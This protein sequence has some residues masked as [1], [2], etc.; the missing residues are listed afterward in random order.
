MV[1]ISLSSSQSKPPHVTQILAACALLL[2]GCVTAR[3]VGLGPA[4]CRRRPFRRPTRWLLP[5]LQGLQPRRRRRL[6]L[7]SRSRVEEGRW[8]G[9]SRLFGSALPQRPPSRSSSRRRRPM[10]ALQRRLAGCRWRWGSLSVSGAVL[11]DG[12]TARLPT[13]LRLPLAPWP[14]LQ[15]LR[16][17]RCTPTEAA[18]PVPTGRPRFHP[19]IASPAGTTSQAC[20]R[21]GERRRLRLRQA[22][23]RSERLLPRRLPM[24]PQ[25]LVAP[26]EV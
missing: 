15:T 3:V 17:P 1:T 18:A 22:V 26:A 8:R 13:R 7:T 25:P 6:R 5:T 14:P 24:H 19:P 9:G 12:C 21:R 10:L 2:A 16:S 11:P 23:P 20:C 4:A